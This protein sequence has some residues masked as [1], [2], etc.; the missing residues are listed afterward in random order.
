LKREK[1][2]KELEKRHQGW[3]KED[4]KVIYSGKMPDVAAWFDVKEIFPLKKMMFEGLEFSV[5]HNPH[6]YL[7]N[8]YS[9]NYMELPPLDKRT[10]HAWSISFN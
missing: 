8:I 4:S 2:V 3:S 9:F 5:P 6:H 1:L 7:E 10:I